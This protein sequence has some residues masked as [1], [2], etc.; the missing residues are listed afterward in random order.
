MAN[1][2]LKASLSPIHDS[3]QDAQVAMSLAEFVKVNGFQPPI[4]RNGSEENS[5]TLLIHRIPQS[6]NEETLRQ[7]FISAAHVVPVA[8]QAVQHAVSSSTMPSGKANAV[9]ASV[10]HAKL[11]FDSLAGPERPD[12]S[13][14]P[15]KRVYLKQGGYICIRKN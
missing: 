15:Q 7:L 11:A 3:V 14:R 9:F 10:E 8:I 4:H 5:A 13:N 2:I 12:K 1:V 6:C